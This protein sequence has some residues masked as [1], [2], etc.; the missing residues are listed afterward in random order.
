MSL[1]QALRELE[2]P[3]PEEEVESTKPKSSEPKPNPRKYGQIKLLRNQRRKKTSKKT[4]SWKRFNSSLGLMA[5]SKTKVKAPATKTRVEPNQK[6]IDLGKSILR[7]R[8]KLFSRTKPPQ[9][10]VIIK[11]L[12]KERDFKEFSEDM[13]T[14]FC[15]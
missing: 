11:S 7:S 12:F 5:A 15:S 3:L 14:L 9:K 1:R 6:M 2:L 13:R 10:P 8:Q 4:K